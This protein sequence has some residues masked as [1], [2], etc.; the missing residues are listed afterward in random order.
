MSP[1]Q[2]V[3]SGI[4]FKNKWSGLLFSWRDQSHFS[5]SL[6]HHL[7]RNGHVDLVKW[8]LDNGA[9]VNIRD[10]LKMTPLMVACKYGQFDL[11]RILMQ[12]G[13]DVNALNCWNETA[14][15]LWLMNCSH[16]NHLTANV[17]LL[18]GKSMEPW[19]VNARSMRESYR[20]YPDYRSFPCGS[21]L[22]H[23]AKKAN[24]G[25]QVVKALL[26][27]GACPDIRDCL[28]EECKA[29]VARFNNI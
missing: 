29:Y 26:E 9:D 13:A 24:A 2:F 28:G 20:G 12:R 25:E 19:T 15:H 27:I 7:C 3:S 17:V 11:L 14:M 18:L 16:M 4:E 23:L 21:T 5:F 6:L 8:A 10:A 22:L 1:S